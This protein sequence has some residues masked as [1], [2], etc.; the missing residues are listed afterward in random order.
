MLPWY[1][2]QIAQH[3]I[4]KDQ[5]LS[6]YVGSVA[7]PWSSRLEKTKGKATFAVILVILYVLIQN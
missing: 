2:G 1:I 5:R 7:V 3:S 4:I 6:L